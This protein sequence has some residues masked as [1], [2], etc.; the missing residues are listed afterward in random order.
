[1]VAVF[2]ASNLTAMKCIEWDAEKYNDTF[3]Q[4]LVTHLI[5]KYGLK[6]LFQQTSCLDIGC[7]SGGV[8]DLFQKLT[9][10][11]KIHGIDISSSMISKAQDVYFFSNEM[12]FEKHSAE[13]LQDSNTYDGIISFCTL[14]WIKHKRCVFKNIFEAL[15]AGGCFFATCDASNENTSVI[16]SVKKLQEEFPSFKKVFSKG[17]SEFEL[18]GRYQAKFEDIKKYLEEAGF[19]DITLEFINFSQEF[20]L[21]QFRTFQKA[22]IFSLP[23]MTYIPEE[24]KKDIFERFT[25]LLFE[26][27]SKN[28][29]NIRIFTLKALVIKAFKPE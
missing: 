18:F 29:E 12:T 4:A 7:G 3:Q 9:N 25:E 10:V 14:H 6:A 28:N 5:E 21:E 2:F 15:K 11:T 19:I 1:M 20:T 13:K 24:E 16:D 8:T 27:L 17:Y 22:Q 26:K 23:L